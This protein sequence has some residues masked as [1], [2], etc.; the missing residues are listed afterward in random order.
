[1]DPFAYEQDLQREECLLFVALTC[2]RDYLRIAYSRSPSA[3]LD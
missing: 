3:F 2:G 1:M